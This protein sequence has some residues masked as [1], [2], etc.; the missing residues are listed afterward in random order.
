M[1]LK[2]TIV[3]VSLKQASLMFESFNFIEKQGSYG[4][5]KIEEEDGAW[6]HFQKFKILS[7]K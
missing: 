4:L 3:F 7:L 5:K 2:D 1:E 6:R